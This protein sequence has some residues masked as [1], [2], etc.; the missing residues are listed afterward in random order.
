MLKIHKRDVGAIVK[1]IISCYTAIMISI[2]KLL[3]FQ[4]ISPDMQSNLVVVVVVIIIRL[5]CKIHPLSLTSYFFHFSLISFSFVILVLKFHSFL[6]ES[7]ISIPLVVAIHL[8]KR[9]HF[10]FLYLN[11]LISKKLKN[12][13]LKINK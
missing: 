11:F 10:D 2:H 5:K 6:I 4:F 1:N 3:V 9:R 8:P 7:S 12:I 13:N